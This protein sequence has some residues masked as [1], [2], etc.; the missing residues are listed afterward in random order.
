MKGESEAVL[1]RVM[2]A[3]RLRRRAEV[4]GPAAQAFNG[5]EEYEAFNIM[6]VAKQP[7]DADLIM[8]TLQ[9]NILFNDITEQQMI[10]IV[11]A[12]KPRKVLEK[13][14]V[15]KEGGQGYT[16][17]IVRKGEFEYRRHHKDG[18]V[19]VRGT[20]GVG[21]CFGEL[22][23]FF[24]APR[25]MSVTCTKRAEVWKLDRPEFRHIV[26]RYQRDKLKNVEAVLRQAVLC[27]GMEETR[28]KAIAE[29]GHY[30]IFRAGDRIIRKGDTAKFFY[31]MI[32]GTV[33]VQN[34]GDEVDLEQDVKLNTTTFSQ[35]EYF[36]EAS[37]LHNEPRSADV[38]CEGICEVL[39][40]D[41]QTAHEFLGSTA[42]LNLLEKNYQERLL[43][44]IPIFEEFNEEGMRRVRKALIP[45]QYPAKKQVIQQG[46]IGNKFYIIRAGQVKVVVDKGTLDEREVLLGQG[47]YFGH[48]ALMNEK[49][50]RRNASV[51]VHSEKVVLLQMTE[52]DFLDI[53]QEMNSTDFKEI[54]ATK[55]S[56]RTLSSEM[57]TVIFRTSYKSISREPR[58][59][60]SYRLQDLKALKVLGSGTFGVV[61]LAQH[62]ETQDTFAL[63]QIQ[64]TKIVAARQEDSVLNEKNLMLQCDHPFIIKL[65]STMK[66]K[67]CLFFLMELVLGGDLFAFLYFRPP[68]YESKDFFLPLKAVKF[69]AGCIVEA[70]DYLHRRHIVY[71]DLKPEN[72]MIDRHGYIKLIDFGFSKKITI[73]S[74]TSC[75]T[76]E[77]LAPELVMQKGHNRGVDFWAL[78]V[79]IYE[80]I[81]GATPFSM[82]RDPNLR[83]KMKIFRNITNHKYHMP[84]QIPQKYRS[85]I[86]GLLSRDPLRRLGMGDEGAAE[87]KNQRC[88]RNISWDD[89]RAREL[90]AHWI[91]PIKSRTDASNFYDE[92]AELTDMNDVTEYNSKE[93]DWEKNF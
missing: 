89:M 79:I 71:R 50:R 87:I 27:I 63:K 3:K 45:V 7:E 4:I 76:P 60:D 51:F 83:D 66:N 19:E 28:I 14:V 15:I 20:A 44:S 57:G 6:N 61:W 68:S 25:T 21:D 40:L 46:E 53:F 81:C 32:S 84:K 74:Y 35:G 34:A 17:Y 85:L 38:F 55:K 78:G 39:V 24:D 23:L 36:G 54:K 48:Y 90:D 69:Y 67:N 80:M 56:R 91:P 70:F 31:F 5:T 10:E 82:T 52:D 29:A 13:N 33:S 43:K 72:L 1:S 30:Q 8:K 49:D 58:A 77:Y 47:A 18:S 16:F 86:E 41:K 59:L 42:Q 2:K 11:Q 73:R 75:G 22:S 26:I 88:F 62:K 12:M 9:K 37:L 93:A 64:K 65:Y 92:E